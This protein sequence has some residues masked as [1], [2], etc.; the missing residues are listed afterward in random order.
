MGYKS[1]VAV[2]A[3]ARLWTQTLFPSLQLPGLFWLYVAQIPGPRN[4]TPS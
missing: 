2:G 1:R 4:L 3:A